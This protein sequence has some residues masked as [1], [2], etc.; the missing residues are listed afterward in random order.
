MLSYDIFENVFFQTRKKRRKH[1]DCPRKYI[2]SVCVYP[3]PVLGQNG[4]TFLYYKTLRDDESA[5]LK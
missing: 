1:D 4:W 3:P 5:V 2:Y